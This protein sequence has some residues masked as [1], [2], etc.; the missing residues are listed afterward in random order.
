MTFTV[1]LFLPAPF[2]SECLS[3][4]RLNKLSPERDQS[5]IRGLGN[6]AVSNSNSFY[7]L[8]Y[9]MISFSVCTKRVGRRSHLNITHSK[10]RLSSYSCHVETRPTFHVSVY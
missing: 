7:Q 2:S 8:G 3:D 4:S 9:F 5:L 1:Q 10:L 6:A